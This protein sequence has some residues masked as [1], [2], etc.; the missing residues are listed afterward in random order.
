[1][2]EI[3]FA[4][5]LADGESARP[6]LKQGVYYR[7]GR[8]ECFRVDA[9]AGEAPVA[10]HQRFMCFGGVYQRGPLGPDESIAHRIDLADYI[11]P[12]SPGPFRLRLR[13]HDTSDIADPEID[14]ERRLT[15]DSAPFELRWT[16]LVLARAD[17]LRIDAAA[18]IA[19]LDEQAPVPIALTVWRPGARCVLGS[20]RPEH[21]LLQS[22]W[23]A[24]PGLLEGLEDC[25]A[26]PSRRAWLLALLFDLTG[27]V[28][29]R[30]H[31]GS[32]GSFYEKAVF[33]HE[34]SPES[35]W[36]QGLDSFEGSVE[37]STDVQAQL[38]ERWTVLSRLVLV[39]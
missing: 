21:D 18:R 25:E 14:L 28:D 33:E 10:P 38:A 2:P 6:T 26:T 32:I 29:P 11:S 19:A 7:S 16:P 22:G 20:S 31:P 3:S 1:L 15:V 23:N 39:E 35:P 12:E 8:F 24:L 13:Y 37:P 30:A 34:G 4:I 17:V 36:R 27:A 9:A 5:E